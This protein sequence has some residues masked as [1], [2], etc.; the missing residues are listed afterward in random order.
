MLPGL[1][2]LSLAATSC[3]KED[4][5]EDPLTTFTVSFPVTATFNG[6]S[7]EPVAGQPVRVDVW[8]N[9]CNDQIRRTELMPASGTTGPDG[10]FVPPLVGYDLHDARDFV[11][12][13][14]TFSDSASYRGSSLVLYSAG[15]L[16]QLSPP[17]QQNVAIVVN[18][19]LR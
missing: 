5:C 1:A 2:L 13:S 8:K 3:S 12:V 18:G 14:A 16:E 7:G 15:V 19:V 17:R 4:G 10:R 9:T 6:V 11:H